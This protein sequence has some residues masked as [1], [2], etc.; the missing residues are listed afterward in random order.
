MHNLDEST[1]LDPLLMLID[2]K[3]YFEHWVNMENVFQAY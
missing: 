3:D 2:I 1:D